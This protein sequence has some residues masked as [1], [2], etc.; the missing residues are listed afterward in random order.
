MI[1]Q[2]E[3]LTKAE[4]FAK[5]GAMEGIKTLFEKYSKLVKIRSLKLSQFCATFEFKMAHRVMAGQ[6][7]SK[8]R[9]I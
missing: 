8:Q 6:G 1:F 4:F 3:I 2:I 5:T 9:Y 7:N